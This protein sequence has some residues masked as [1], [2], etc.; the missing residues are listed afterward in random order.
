MVDKNTFCDTLKECSL[1][2]MRLIPKCDMH[3]HAGRGEI[4][5]I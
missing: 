3:N 4:F 2:K 1:E 5:R